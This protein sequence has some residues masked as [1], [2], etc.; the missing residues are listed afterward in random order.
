M[1]KLCDE[2]SGQSQFEFNEWD[3]SNQVVFDSTER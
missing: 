3:P 1:N 2:L